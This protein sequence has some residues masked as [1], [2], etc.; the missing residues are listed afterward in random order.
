[1][2]RFFIDIFWFPFFPKSKKNKFWLV[3]RFVFKDFVAYFYSRPT[4]LKIFLFPFLLIHLICKKTKYEIFG[5][6][7]Q[8]VL[9]VFLFLIWFFIYWLYQYDYDLRFFATKICLS[10]DIT[11]EICYRWWKIINYPFI[12][13]KTY[14]ANKR[15]DLENN[16]ST[17]N[18]DINTT[19]IIK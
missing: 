1:M 13:D 3:L 8:I 16:V 10:N 7:W 12:W 18:N 17:W 5:L 15:P 2:L 9:S 14:K 4:F 11:L 6:F 19:W